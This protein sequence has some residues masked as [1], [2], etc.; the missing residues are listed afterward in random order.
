MSNTSQDNMLG[1]PWK[2]HSSHIS[3]EK[4]AAAAEELRGTDTLNVKVR[5]YP[6]DV[7]KVKTRSTVAKTETSKKKKNKDTSSEETTQTKTR[8]KDE[9]PKTRAQRRSEKTRRKEQQK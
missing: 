9:R 2:T 8:S 3:Y 7:F 5:R 6:D 4:A 1:K